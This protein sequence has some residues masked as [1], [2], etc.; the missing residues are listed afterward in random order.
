MQGLDSI[1]S[2]QSKDAIFRML[3]EIY[4]Q[5]MYDVNQ[6]EDI[7]LFTSGREDYSNIGTDSIKLSVMKYV[8][9]NIFWMSVCLFV[10]EDFRS[11]FDD[12]IAIE[13]MLL[14]VNDIE[15]ADFRDD[16]TLNEKIN[17][18][19]QNVG[20]DL[21]NYRPEIDQAIMGSIL[22]AE[23][24]FAN[25]GMVNV[26]KELIETFDKEVLN[27]VRYTVHNYVY[28]INAMNR[29]GIFNKYVKLVVNSV[30]KQ[31]S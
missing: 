25:A 15:Y 14:Q 6:I 10:N 3:S 2:Q 20:I 29:N 13:K 5:K 11:C 23:K 24:A 18:P 8:T 9:D 26:Y 30:K 27:A 17:E 19:D 31:L 7:V 1:R 21:N 16:M 22:N 28:V 12:A 4:D